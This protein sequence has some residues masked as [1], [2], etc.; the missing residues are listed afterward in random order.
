M[1][2]RTKYQ[3]HKALAKFER[4]LKKARSPRG[5]IEPNIELLTKHQRKDAAADLQEVLD[6]IIEC[7]DL[8]DS[9]GVTM[10]AFRLQGDKSYSESYTLRDATEEE[11]AAYA[12]IKAA[13]EEAKRK[14]EEE[15]KAEDPDEETEEEA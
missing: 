11:R 5:E 8:I 3:A 2:D 7:E 12:E 14:A 9:L 1:D 10:V 4:L 6:R 13:R 15:A